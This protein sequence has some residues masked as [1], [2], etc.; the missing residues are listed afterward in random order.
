MP[1]RDDDVGKKL[2]DLITARVNEGLLRKARKLELPDGVITVVFTDVEGSSELVRD[3]G[4]QGAHTIL[5]RHDVT[6]RQ[7]LAE[8]DGLE[9]EQAG[10]GFMLAFRSPSN[11]VAFAL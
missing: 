9:V 10:D 5:R 11:A 2:N 7:V 6:V 8:H 3:L 1:R 4:D